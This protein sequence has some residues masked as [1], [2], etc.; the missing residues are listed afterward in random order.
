MT[1]N[2]KILTRATSLIT[3]M[4]FVVST[5]FFPAANAFA[6]TVPPVINHTPPA[7]PVLSV[8]ATVTDDEGLD[9]EKVELHYSP[10][11]TDDWLIAT[12]LR[13]T[14]DTFEYMFVPSEQNIEIDYYITAVDLAGNEQSAGFEFDPLQLTTAQ[15]ASEPVV[16]PQ[17][18]KSNT[19]L[20][21]LGAVALAALVAGASGGG[22]DGGTTPATF[23][24][25]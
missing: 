5:L 20:Y 21:V 25:N 18:K 11:S 14:G 23:F 7:T 12:M 22:D 17:A 9:G 15:S 6:D 1:E 2:N 19:L 13:S 3:S 24:I 10:A 8:S 4:L 16:A